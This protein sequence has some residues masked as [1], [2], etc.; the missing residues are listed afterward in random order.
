M[1]ILS[2]I[3]HNANPVILKMVYN[4]SFGSIVLYGAHLC[5]KTKL[6]NQNSIQVL[7]NCAINKVWVKKVR[8]Q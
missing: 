2:K 7:Q 5:G 6:A 4:S 1:C 8:S 3:R